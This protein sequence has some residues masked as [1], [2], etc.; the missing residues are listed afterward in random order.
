MP[1]ISVT[2]EA[3]T[4]QQLAL[5]YANLSFL[6]PDGPDVGSKLAKE[7]NAVGFFDDHDKVLVVIISGRRPG[8]V[9]T[10][11]TIRFQVLE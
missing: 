8:V 5:W 2:S 1:I 10:T 6:R 9:G 7:L 4:A 3:R 11:D